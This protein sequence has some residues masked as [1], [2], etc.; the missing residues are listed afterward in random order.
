MAQ[1]L[2]EGEQVSAR[3]TR[4]LSERQRDVI[5]ALGRGEPYKSVAAQ[6]GISE[7]SVDTHRRRAFRN[8]RV[9][10]L[11]DA[12]LRMRGREARRKKHD[13]QNGRT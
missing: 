7:S 11:V 13:R 2:G 10:N 8:L 4:E 1:G 5:A 12:V 3:L 6:L 9:S